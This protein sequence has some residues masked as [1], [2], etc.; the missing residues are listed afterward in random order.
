MK[1]KMYM[2]LFITHC[3][4]TTSLADTISFSTLYSI[5]SISKSNSKNIFSSEPSL[6]SL[7]EPLGGLL[8][9]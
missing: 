1:V 4:P 8:F 6:G 5:K 2:S 9:S 3:G 7:A